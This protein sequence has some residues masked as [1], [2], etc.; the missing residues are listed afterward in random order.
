[1]NASLH[2]NDSDLPT[3]FDTNNYE[4]ALCSSLFIQ[5]YAYLPTFEILLLLR[6]FK[7]P[8]S[9][10]ER[11]LNLQ[12]WVNLHLDPKYWH[13]QKKLLQKLARTTAAILVSCFCQTYY[14][15]T[16]L[17]YPF[18]A[19]STKEYPKLSVNTKW[20]SPFGSLVF[21]QKKLHLPFQTR[22]A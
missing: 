12:C 14:K 13:A 9:F 11:T 10:Q 6:T 18:A 22:K 17:F 8:S 21:T 4:T 5:T 16:R 7:S 19:K 1:M 15:C 20:K 2:K 3:Q